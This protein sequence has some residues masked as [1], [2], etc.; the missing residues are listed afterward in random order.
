[1][2][3]RVRA[4]KHLGELLT[5]TQPRPAIPRSDYQHLLDQAADWHLALVHDGVREQAGPGL[6]VEHELTDFQADFLGAK[7]ELLAARRQVA[8]AGKAVF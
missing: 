2:G 7:Q 6:V 3:A 4:A 8:A 1:M 5:E